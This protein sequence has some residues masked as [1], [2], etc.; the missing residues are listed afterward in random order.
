M[1]RQNP[2]GITFSD[3]HK[4]PY[5]LDEEYVDWDDDDSTYGPENDG[6]NDS[7]DDDDDDESGD[8]YD[9]DNERDDVDVC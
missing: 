9:S 3:R 8:E 4:V 6:R 5:M 7:D 1:A 2:R